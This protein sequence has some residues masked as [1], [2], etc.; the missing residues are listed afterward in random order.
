MKKTKLLFTLL[1]V[2]TSVCL[3]AQP[4]AHLPCEPEA[5]RHSVGGPKGLD[6]ACQCEGDGGGL[7]TRSEFDARTPESQ[8][9]GGKKSAGSVKWYELVLSQISDCGLRSLG[10]WLL[11]QGSNLQPFG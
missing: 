4:P 2:L 10:C 8:H 5:L 3:Q 9:G 6:A 11:G 7:R 1:G